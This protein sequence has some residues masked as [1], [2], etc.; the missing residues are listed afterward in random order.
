MSG[1]GA[2]WRPIGGA[3]S[4]CLALTRLAGWEPIEGR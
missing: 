1:M 2:G 4:A 3:G